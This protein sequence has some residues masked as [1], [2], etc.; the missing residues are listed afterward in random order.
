MIKEKDHQK[1]FKFMSTSNDIEV[2]YGTIEN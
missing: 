1:E 2:N